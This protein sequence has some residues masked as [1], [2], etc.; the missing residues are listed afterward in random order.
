MR[1]LK[2]LLIPVIVIILLVIGLLFGLRVYGDYHPDNKNIKSL[3]LINPLEPTKEYYVKTNKPIKQK[4]KESSNQ[5][6][7][8]KTTGYD[9]NGNSKKIKYVGMKRLKLNHYLKIKKKL[10]TVKSYEEVKKD[11]IPKEARK[12]LN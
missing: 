8:Y 10:D 6:H 5:T 2:I 12:H 9:K 7:V 4:P 11:D 1:E 3:N